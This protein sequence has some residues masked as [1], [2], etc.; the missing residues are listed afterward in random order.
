MWSFWFFSCE[1]DYVGLILFETIPFVLG[2]HLLLIPEPWFDGNIEGRY[3]RP[4]LSPID[5]LN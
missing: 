2:L 5:S 1:R 4:T 3:V